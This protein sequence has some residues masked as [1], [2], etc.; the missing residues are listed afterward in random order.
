MDAL[1]GLGYRD[2]TVVVTGGSSGM[3]EATVR[4]LDELGAH[5][6]VVDLNEPTVGHA[7][8]YAT[9]ISDPEQVSDAAARLREIGPIQFY[10]S[11]AGISHTFGPLRCMLVNYVG[12]R[13]LIDETVPAL[14]DAAGIAVISSQA[15]MGWQANLATNLELLAIAD[16]VAAR[17]W[18]EKH[19]EAVRDGYS[20]SKE[21][22]IVWAMHEAIRL[23]EER[24][25]RV[26]C[27]APCPTNTAFMT[28]T[29]ADLGQ[30]FFDR[31]PYPVLGRMATAEEQAWPLL[32]LNSPL[33]AVVSGTVLYTDQGFSGGVLAGSLDVSGLM[34]TDGAT[35]EN[36]QIKEEQR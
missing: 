7:A 28:P 33:N 31:Y 22:L 3:G 35:E 20:V 27:I 19:P 1:E 16:P 23:G 29:I 13:Q 6:H 36:R 34:P 10:F 11:C 4:I 17:A 30:E 32:L 8:F 2:S 9:D 26:N 18:C 21:M 15:G 12:A 5:V 24:H 25:I 14:A